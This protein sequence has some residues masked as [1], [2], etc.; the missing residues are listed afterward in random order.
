MI[1]ALA[2]WIRA[3]LAAGA[4]AIFI[5][6]VPGLLVITAGWPLRWLGWT[7]PTAAPRVADLVSALTSPW[8]DSMLFA[9][10]ATGGWLLW[11]LFV[12]DVLVEVIAACAEVSQQRAGRGSPH[13]ARRGPMRTVAAILIGAIIGAILADSIRGTLGSPAAS[14]AAAADAAAHRPA[15]AVAP[16]RPVS[17]PLTDHLAT[18]VQRSTTRVTPV[19][20]T[21][22]I[23]TSPDIP[24]WAADAPGGIHHV[25]KGDNLWDI[26]EAR[27]GDPYRWR[28]I[29][30]L[31]RGQPQAGGYRLTDPDEIDIGWVLALPA[32]DP[33][34]AASPP[35][36]ADPTQ[37]EPAPRTSPSTARSGAPSAAASDTSDAPSHHFEDHTDRGIT[38]P[39]EGWISL[40]LAAAIAIISALVRLRARRQARPEFPIPIR[41]EPGPSPVPAPIALA[42][43]AASR[44]SAAGSGADQPAGT[45][46]PDPPEVAAP[47]G[48][49]PGGVEISLFALPG[50]GLALSGP[51]AEP[52][53]RA[54]LAA[55]LTTAVLDIP[56]RRP[57]VVTT[58]GALA[59]LLPDGV[60]PAGLDLDGTAFE[61]ERLLVLADPVAAI[62]HAEEEMITRRRILDTL[63]L[64]CVADLNAEPDLDDP[65]PPYVLL[66][67]ATARHAARI[68]A[69]GTHRRALDLHPIL[70]GPQDGF[71]TIEV[72]ADGTPTHDQAEIG[73]LSTLAAAD[74]AALLDM[75]ASTL[76]R[77]EAGT[78]VDDPP[79]ASTGHPAA[80]E[81]VIIPA[82]SGDTPP[83]V[84]LTVLGPITLTTDTGPV[85]TGM[86]SGS[87]AVLAV[88]AAH[89][90]GRSPEQLAAHLHPSLGP[91]TA[92]KRIRTDVGTVRSVLRKATGAKDAK[93][94]IFDRGIDRYHLEA[95]TVT[96][97]LWRML[98]ALDRANTAN[99]D[100]ACLTALR[101]AVGLYQGDFAE[102]DDRPWAIDDATCYR[103]Q[104]LAAYA[105]IAEL[106]ELDQPEQAIRALETAIDLDPV[107]EELYQRL[108]RIQGRLHRPDAVR[109]T[110]RRLEARL[111]ELGDVEPSEATRRVA[112]R[113]LRPNPVGGRR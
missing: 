33:D 9:V 62:T 95:D 58:I 22:S 59:R 8:S 42:Y 10:L 87:Y 41:T 109:R 65:Q 105:R 43:Q 99:D 19:A 2:R 77:P 76:P 21:V 7:H 55:A 14:A 32:R 94:I 45:T 72:S 40:G 64:A 101:D 28:E 57:I 12:R 66:I 52:A 48:L 35:A 82:A 11:A 6:G 54:I 3:L 93:F 44:S 46:M 112:E 111:F 86:R 97:D 18:P 26:A 15:V 110:L 85:T 91:D 13:V 61:G 37:P 29:Y 81:P 53:A 47:V 70:L 108:I 5:A 4:L 39:T 23:T 75:I 100:P 98:A 73:R 16:A 107:N 89:P 104:I 84:R 30:Q 24:D 49:D 102:G 27:L 106:T 78:S 74:L 113:Q 68:Q 90:A 38:L 17:E 63:D 25:V 88:L 71:P 36:Q 103:H 34:Q 56:D 60:A 1:R 80:V 67:D 96:V 51:G 79:T 50:P 83:L 31:N 69:V 92:I 20:L